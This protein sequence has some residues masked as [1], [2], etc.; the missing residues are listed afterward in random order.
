MESRSAERMCPQTC[1][2]LHRTKPNGTNLHRPA[3]Q[4]S[5][6][7]RLPEPILSPETQVRIPVAVLRGL[8][9][10]WR[11]PLERRSCWVVRTGLAPAHRMS[12]CA[13]AR[14]GSPR[15]ER[16]RGRERGCDAAA[17]ATDRAMSAPSDGANSVSTYWVEPGD[18]TINQKSSEDGS[19]RGLNPRGSIA[20]QSATTVRPGTRSNSVALAVATSMP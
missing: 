14:A 10:F 7:I 19:K 12:P 18:L 9:R 16:R 20:G 6:A 3:R 4:R 1:P 15:Q 13:G 2:R 8:R 5:T 17:V 11:T